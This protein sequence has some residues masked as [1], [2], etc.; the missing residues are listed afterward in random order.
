MNRKKILLL[1]LSNKPN[2]EAFDGSTNSGKLI[3]L[4]I[5]QC[6]DCDFLKANLVSFAPL[7]TNNKLR[8]PT[9][10][11]LSDGAKKWSEKML[12]FDC[13]V[14]FGNK[15]Q[16]AIKKDNTLSINYICAPHPSYIWIYKHKEIEKYVN[17]ITNKINIIMP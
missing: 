13:V 17:E 4:I 3:D 7:D 9:K 11:E 8:Y 14:L 16:N 6:P 15:V 2:L 10:E 12:E 5:S 1:G